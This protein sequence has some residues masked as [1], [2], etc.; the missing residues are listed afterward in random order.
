MP[1]QI[2][3]SVGLFGAVLLFC[4]DMLLYYSKDDYKSDGTLKPIIDI[5]K[6]ASRARLYSGG[7]IGPVAAFLY[8]IGFYHLVLLVDQRHLL[9]GWICFFINCLAIILG[10]SY[11]N[12][13]ANLGLIGRHDDELALTETLKFLEFQKKLAFGLQAIGF[14]AMALLIAFGWTTLPRWM[15]MFTPL[16]LVLLT[17][18]V[19]KLPKRFHMIICGGWTNLISVIYYVLTIVIILL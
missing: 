12:Y 5:M 9:F 4:G 17:P 13:F 3:L 8:C 14:F 6:K 16:T 1:L 2:T 15:V 19:E 10:G 18:I 11:H 7:I